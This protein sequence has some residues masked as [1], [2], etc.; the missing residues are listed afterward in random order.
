VSEQLAGQLAVVTG[1]GS[2]IGRAI[3]LALAA[4]G[5]DVCLAGRRP[6]AL[7]ETATEARRTGARGQ[8]WVFPLDVSDD[9]E[10]TRLRDRLRSEHDGVD[11]LVHAAGAHTL[12]AIDETPVADLDAQYRINVRGPYL[13]TQ[14][15]LPFLRARRG[16]IVFLNSTA[17]LQARARVG[18]YAASKHALRALADT[19]RE[20]INPDGVR[21]LSVYPGRT[22]TPLQAAI[23]A[24]E[25]R[26][27]R[28]ERLLQPEDVAAAVVHT[29]ALDRT[30]EVTDLRVRPMQK[31]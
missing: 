10:L 20:E 8:T 26:P 11:I 21:V 1:A 12:G 6:D 15:L 17:G 18:A 28:P 31:A 22:A 5:V 24:A 13:L 7:D 2:G 9:I 19:L 25:G 3:A 16:Q 30:A 14:L 27:Y 4:D 29:L 23:H